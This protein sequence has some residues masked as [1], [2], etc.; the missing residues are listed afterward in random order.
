[1]GRKARLHSAS[2]TELVENLRGLLERGDS[3]SM[4]FM[5]VRTTSYGL[6]AGVLPEELVLDFAHGKW[7]GFFEP[8]RFRTFCRRGVELSCWAA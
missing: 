3:M 4:L 6:I 1:M 5:T 2:K 7:R 8:S